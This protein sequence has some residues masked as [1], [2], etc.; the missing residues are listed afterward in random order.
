M[1]PQ[2]LSPAAPSEELGLEGGTASPAWGGTGHPSG[3]GSA[4]RTEIPGLSLLCPPGAGVSWAQIIPPASFLPEK[5]RVVVAR[6]P[7]CSVSPQKT[8]LEKERPRPPCCP[9][10]GTHAHTWMVLCHLLAATP[11]PCPVP[12][13]P[14]HFCKH[15]PGG[16]WVRDGGEAPTH[17]GTPA[18]MPG[19]AALALWCLRAANLPL[20]HWGPHACPSPPHPDLVAPSNVCV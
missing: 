19:R 8:A 20:P 2:L 18:P 9:S 17:C 3:T 10:A 1:E 6:G 14:G 16:T 5:G 15:W 4:Q 7:R 11:L 12:I 13:L